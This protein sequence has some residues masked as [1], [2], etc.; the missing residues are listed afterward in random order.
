[1][2]EEI[3]IVLSIPLLLSVIVLP[4]CLIKWL[5]W[6]IRL[7]QEDRNAFYKVHRIFHDQ[8]AQE[9]FKRFVCIPLWFV[10]FWFFFISHNQC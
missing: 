5:F 4:F 8:M 3:R 2:C 1:M 7:E 10:P 6:F 9:H